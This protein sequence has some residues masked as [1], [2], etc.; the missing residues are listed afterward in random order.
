MERLSDRFEKKLIEQ[1]LAL[2]GEP[3]LGELDVDITWNRPDS[4]VSILSQVFDRLNINSLLLSR[5]AE[6][7]GGIIDCLIEENTHT[8]HLKDNE[9]RLF[10][11]DIP[12]V[13]SFSA[14]LIADRLKHRKSVIIEGHG[15][16]TCGTVSP[17]Q[18][19]IHFSSVVFACF[20]NYFSDF[21]ENA[22]K[23]RLSEDRIRTFKDIYSRLQP[24]PTAPIGLAKG[25]FASE[26]SVKKAI[27]SAGRPVVAYGLVD[28]VMGNISYLWDDTL[29]ISQTGAFLDELTECIDA[30]P[31][32]KSACTGITASSELPTHMRIVK[33]TPCRAILHGHPKFSVIM[34]L[35]CDKRDRCPH[36]GACHIQCP[37]QRFVAGIP[38]VP[39]ESGSGKKAIVNTVPAAVSRYPAVI[40]YGHGVFTA[41]ENDFNRPFSMLY[42]TEIKCRTL[43]AKRLR[44][45]GIL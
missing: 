11:H 34:S 15:I 31:L 38:I 2:P 12:V 18:L 1:H 45:A 14:D 41:G 7:Y 40:V 24:I 17:E 30:C 37:E 26:E 33:E 8:I 23:G 20:V 22:V 16:L 43:Y 29:Y 42:D 39:G 25:P 21:A 6:P 44:T 9:T 5:P 4:R 19:F 27:A 13:R 3:V 10:F 36:A 28:S 35:I 32:D